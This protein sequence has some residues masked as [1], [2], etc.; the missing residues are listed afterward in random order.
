V[1]TAIIERIPLRLAGVVYTKP[2]MVELI[3]DLAGYLP[4]RPLARLIA[5]EPSAGDGAFLQGMVRR[6]IESCR[7]HSI[8]VEQAAHAIGAF[9]IDPEAA[10]KAI[11]VVCATLLELPIPSPTAAALARSWAKT[12]DFL[13][14]SFAFSVISTRTAKEQT[15][16][17]AKSAW[18][19]RDEMTTR[20]QPFGRIGSPVFGRDGG[21]IDV[22]CNFRIGPSAA[23]D[24]ASCPK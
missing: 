14:F 5:L 24:V 13:E 4:E 3:L 16:T 22:L 15:A 20:A 11:G 18:I 7:L 19:G 17:K 12:D 23:W 2:W 6:L 8:P 10:K 21:S 9:E 1:N